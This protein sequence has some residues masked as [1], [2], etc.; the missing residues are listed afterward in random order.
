MHRAHAHTRPPPH[1]RSCDVF[2]PPGTFSDPVHALCVVGRLLWVCTGNM[3]NAGTMVIFDLDT[4]A[5][6]TKAS[7]AVCQDHQ[8]LQPSMAALRPACLDA[9]VD[10]QP[11]VRARPSTHTRTHAAARKPQ[12]FAAHKGEITVMCAGPGNKYIVTG[13]VDFQVRAHMGVRAGECTLGSA[14][15]GVYG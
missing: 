11:C 5:I 3:A 7:A 13:S 14:R 2:L 1:P 10:P 9:A 15:W 6:V 8:R 12:A 4:G